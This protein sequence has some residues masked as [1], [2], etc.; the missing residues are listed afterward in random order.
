[1]IPEMI[2]IKNGKLPDEPGVYFYYDKRGE[3]L[4][5]GKA[6]SLKRRVESYFVKAHTRRTEELVARIARIEYEQL[7]TVL[8]ALVLEANQIRAHQPFYNV[9]QKDDKSFCYLA[10]TNEQYPRPFILRGLE[11][12]RLGV[13]PFERKL[14]HIA[15]KQFLTLFGP[16]MSA[17]SLRVALDLVRKFIPWSDCLPGA[18]RACFSVSIGLCPGVCIKTISP[19]AYRKYIRDLILF[20]RGRTRELRTLLRERM[21]NAAR[22]ERFEEAATLRNRL[23]ALDHIR[24]VAL[25]QRDVPDVRGTYEESGIDLEGRIE[26]YDISNISGTSAVGSM[27]VFEHGK[28]AKDKYRRFKIRTV[29]GA[30]DVAMMEEVLRRR[31]ARARR[32]PHAWPLPEV[33]VIDGGEGQVRTVVEEV[34]KIGKGGKVPKVIGIAKGFDRKQDRLVFDHHDAELARVATRGKELFQ[35]ARDEAHRFAVAYH[36]K[37]RTRFS[38]GL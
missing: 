1:M 27:V 6:T 30:N 28:P 26:A 21:E 17:Q 38:L 18:R 35:R 5:I 3:L 8:E 29:K 11:L 15:R 2:T 25:I 24:D 31:L 36:R 4:Y 10:I 23:F 13:R 20:F 34:G 33:L 16:Y 7:P 22:R 14:S 37:L 32:Q 12:E 19:T 9:R